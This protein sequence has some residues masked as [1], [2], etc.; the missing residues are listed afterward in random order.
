MIITIDGSAGTGKTTVAKMV[1]ERLQLP[2][3]DTGA[4]YRAV[5]FLILQ[6]GIS[7]K[8]EEAVLALLDSF[9]FDI[10]EKGD[11]KRYFAN[12][13]EVT[14]EI[15]S[16]AI[17]HK[18]SEVAALPLVRKVLWKIQRTFVKKRGG[19]FEGR[20]M[21]TVVFP[22][23]AFKFFLKASSEVRAERRLEEIMLKRPQEAQNLDKHKMKEEL[24]RRDEYD[25][26]RALAPLKCP[27]DAYVIDTSE[28]SIEEVV[29]DIL[30]YCTKKDLRVVWK[31][32]KPMK[33]VYRITIFFAWAFLKIFYSHKVYGLEHFY[34][35]GALIVAN[36]ASF[37]DPPILSISW[38][39][40]VHF[41]ARETLFKNKIFGSFI[42]SV[43]THPVSGNVGDVAVF[44]TICSLVNE[45]EKVILFPEGTRS[46][47]GGLGHI[48]PGVGMLIGRTESAII[49][50]YIQGS[51]DIWNRH[52]KFPKLFGKT[53]C[54]FGSPICWRDFK[55]LGKREAQE[56][57]AEKV[58]ESILGLKAW[59]EAGAR[60]ISP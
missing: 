9:Q 36:H 56:K 21:G 30:E 18:V 24:M 55:H 20:D 12:N 50:A 39:E 6:K 48:K 43:N 40:E 42:R 54:V 17:S 57:V 33:W 51:F 47:K 10:Q 13:Q 58:A 37:L 32:P 46:D 19:V 28:I 2:Y 14:E 41:L 38:P 60:G 22:H 7:L 16:Q 59:L 27:Q 26:S 11:H 8:D 45:G 15:R 4:M 44:K 52:R 35:K 29:D 53:A 3:F 5:T 49:P 23:A 1:A 25:S 31:Q 34:P